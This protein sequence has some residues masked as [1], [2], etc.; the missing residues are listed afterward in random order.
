VQVLD[1]DGSRLLIISKGGHANFDLGS[2]RIAT[3]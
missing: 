2:P 3:P 1:G